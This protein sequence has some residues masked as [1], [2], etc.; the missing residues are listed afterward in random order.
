MRIL[1]VGGAGF[2]GTNLASKLMDE[3]HE[4]FILDSLLVNNV[5]ATQDFDPLHRAILN[6]R[7][8]ILDRTNMV[9]ADARDYTTF[10]PLCRSFKPEVI[11]HLAAVAHQDRAQK[12]PHTTFDHSLRTL[13]NSLDVATN[14]GV[15]RFIYFSSSTVY[16]AWPD[17][18]VVS[19]EMECLPV[20][21]Y[22]SLKLAGELMVRAYTHAT[23]L[24][25]I[26]VRPS[27]LYGPGCI[28]G[29]VIQ[30]FI[31]NALQ[32]K[33]LNVRLNE[34]LDFTHIKD[35]VAGVSLAIRSKKPNET[36]NLTRGEGRTIAQAAQLVQEHIPIGIT[37]ANDGGDFPLRG[38]LDI[39]KAKAQ[40]GYNPWYSL[41][42][43][44]TDY[45]QWYR[46]FN[47]QKVASSGAFSLSRSQ[48]KRTE[49]SGKRTGEKRPL[50]GAK[51]EGRYCTLKSP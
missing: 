2:I 11:V 31:E 14:V 37:I 51:N 20:G 15:K 44:I 26:I 47:A 45:I 21:I 36:Y 50:D 35:L 43:G 32:G 29:R 25:H 4:I 38:T 27:A 3:G 7:K 28:S 34:S 18:G 24:E 8:K 23:G 48:G 19:E 13:E 40:L 16:G 22:G 33:D 9:I 49:S 41:E 12:S 42:N 10:S 30:R 17:T 5:L 46:G 6:D 39:A 1:L